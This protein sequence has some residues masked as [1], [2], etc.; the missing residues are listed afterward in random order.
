MDCSKT[1]LRA[2]SL[3][4]LEHI[5]A[6]WP[7]SVQIVIDACQMR[8]GRNRI[9]HY[10]ARNFMVQITGS[11]FFTGPPFSGA[12]LIPASLSGA[13]SL[14]PAAPAGLRDYTSKYSWPL[15]WSG[16]RESFSSQPN[17]GEWLRWEAALEEM[18]CYFSVPRSFRAFALRT[19][20]EL[21]PKLIS[22]EGNLRS[23]KSCVSNTQ[24]S[25][26]DEELGVPTIF[27]FLIGERSRELRFDDCLRIYRKLGQLAGNTS[28]THQIGQPV[29]LR[30]GSRPPKGALRISASARLI[31]QSWSSAHPANAQ[32]ALKRKIEE[33]GEILQ[34]LSFGAR[35]LREQCTSRACHS[36]II[37]INSARPS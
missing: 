18:R 17:Y 22:N 19:F 36:E 13:L 28:A 8:L 26:D 11:K 31:S 9:R 15:G 4:C 3:A 29:A 5:S 20:S 2:P 27:P 21:V 37:E 23:P 32:N 30:D 33:L 1:G 25:I 24:D 6:T 7:S 10:L 12:L 16:I 14:V 34:R 35:E